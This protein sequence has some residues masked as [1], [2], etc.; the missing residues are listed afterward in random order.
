MGFEI[1]LSLLSNEKEHMKSI[2]IIGAGQLGSRHLQ[3]SKRAFELLDIW[4]MD[5]NNDSIEIAKERYEQID[6]ISK[7]S[8]YFINDFRHLPIELDVVIVSTSSKPRLS[9]IKALLTHCKVKYLILEKF[10]FPKLSDYKEALE[11]I[12]VNNIKAWVNCPYRIQ[13]CYKLVHDSLDKSKKIH[14]ELHGEKWGL[15]C[16]AIH[17]ID[18]LMWL[19]NERSFNIDMKDI[20]PEIVQSKRTGYIELEGSLHI[21]TPNGNTMTLESAPQYKGE[22][23]MQIKNGDKLITVN[24]W[25]GGEIT[26]NGVFHDSKFSYQSELTGIL[27]DTLLS[28]ET[29]GL[30]SYQES[31][32]Y[33]TQFLSTVLAYVNKLQGEESDILP[34]T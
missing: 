7:K 25:S 20:I 8:V 15:C 34:I 6:S 17:Y 10:L 11:I 18:L 30:V 9:V 12:E 5:T 16:N 31:M 23:V 1:N 22:M 19:T 26:I 2:A 29:C 13:P 21:S 3:G 27:L 4:V 14:L 33:H 28:T 32:E 24:E